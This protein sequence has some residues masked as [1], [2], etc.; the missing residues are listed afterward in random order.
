M[1]FEGLLTMEEGQYIEL[2]RTGILPKIESLAPE[3]HSV[4]LSEAKAVIDNL[5]SKN[6]ELKRIHEEFMK[7]LTR[8]KNQEIRNKSFLTT[9]GINRLGWH[10]LDR[11]IHRRPL[12][13]FDLIDQSSSINIDENSTELIDPS[14]YAV[15]PEEGISTRTK[16]GLNMIPRGNFMAFGFKVTETGEILADFKPSQTGEEVR[17]Y[18]E[19]MTRSEFEEQV[20]G[21]Q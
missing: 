4:D 2:L 6:K 15:W 19:K 11:L 10:N 1:R 5:L 14:Y 12:R 17:L 8:E 9:F 21:F 7:H 13:S 20:R 18:L 16:K 3:K